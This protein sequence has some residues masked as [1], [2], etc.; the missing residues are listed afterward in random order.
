MPAS[1]AGLYALRPTLNTVG[2]DG[3]F[4]SSIELDIVGGLARS[5][6]DLALLSQTA[7]TEEN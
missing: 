2:M 5:I 6:V 4:Q 7:L 3:V 1:R